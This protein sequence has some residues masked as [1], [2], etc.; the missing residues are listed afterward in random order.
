MVPVMNQLGIHCAVFGN[1]DFGKYKIHVFKMSLY[2]SGTVVYILSYSKGDNS[3]TKVSI[4][5]CLS[6]M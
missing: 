2:F 4:K 5:K 1:H 3:S 6:H